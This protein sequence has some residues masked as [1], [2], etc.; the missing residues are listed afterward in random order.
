MTSDTI[1]IKSG[2]FIHRSIGLE[3]VAVPLGTEA[4]DVDHLINLNETAAFFIDRLDGQKTLGQLA[5]ELAGEYD[6]APA[7]ALA[8]LTALCGELVTENV[9]TEQVS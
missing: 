1:F 6:A 2:R 5:A 3:H 9:I 8:D 7:E 4:A